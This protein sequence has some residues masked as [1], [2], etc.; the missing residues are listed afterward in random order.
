VNLRVRG[1]KEQHFA[2]VQ[3]PLPSLAHP[4]FPFPFGDGHGL[5]ERGETAHFPPHDD[6][7]PFRRLPPVLVVCLEAV[8][9][10]RAQK[11]KQQQ[12][13]ESSSLGGGLCD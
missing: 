11:K 1:R 3:L 4:L 6:P 10:R 13:P 5:G 12:L 2:T 8:F 7:S 9:W